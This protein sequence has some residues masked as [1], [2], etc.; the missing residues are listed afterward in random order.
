MASDLVG[1][2][3]EILNEQKMIYIEANNLRVR[4]GNLKQKIADIAVE[5]REDVRM[6]CLHNKIQLVKIGPAVDAIAAKITQAL[7]APEA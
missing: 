5:D 6:I 3:N 1:L 4:I 7:D 2:A